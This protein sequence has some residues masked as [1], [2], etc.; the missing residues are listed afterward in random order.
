MAMLLL[1]LGLAQAFHK[2]ECEQPNL[3][4][5]HFNVTSERHFKK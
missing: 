3:S 4:A 5:G 2:S 1:L